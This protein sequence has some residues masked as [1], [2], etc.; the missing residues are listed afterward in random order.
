MVL[1][2]LSS[3][4]IDAVR[5]YR[6]FVLH[7]LRL[8]CCMHRTL[9]HPSPSGFLC[10]AWICLYSGLR[11]RLQHLYAHAHTVSKVYHIQWRL[12][13]TS[14]R[15]WLLPSISSPAIS[16]GAQ[17]KHPRS[18]PSGVRRLGRTIAR[19]RRPAYRR[20]NRRANGPIP[21]A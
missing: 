15:L 20:R 8:P 7:A 12:R 6:C 11:L 10:R 21:G 1:K 2:A 14:P 19:G 3:S 4:F 9:I 16:L 18:R 13:G 17:P 5:R